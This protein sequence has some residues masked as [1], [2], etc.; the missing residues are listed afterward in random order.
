V[1]KTKKKEKPCNFL[2]LDPLMTLVMVLGLGPLMAL[3]MVIVNKSGSLWVITNL[4]ISPTCKLYF[5]LND[6]QPVVIEL[7]DLLLLNT[8]STFIALYS[9][10][11]K[12]AI[13]SDLFKYALEKLHGITVSIHEP[14]FLEISDIN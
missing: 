3:V 10:T 7:E 13:P 9:P 11:L 1:T 5:W 6:F 8:I 2:G 12:L 4:H 14:I